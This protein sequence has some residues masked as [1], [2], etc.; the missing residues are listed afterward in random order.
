MVNNARLVAVLLVSF[1]TISTTAFA[2]NKFVTTATDCK[3]AKEKY[4]TASAKY[5][6]QPQSEGDSVLNLTRE[7]GAGEKFAMGIFAGTERGVIIFTPE[8]NS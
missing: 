6:I 7:P 3:T 2:K 8:T 5:G 1:L 4:T